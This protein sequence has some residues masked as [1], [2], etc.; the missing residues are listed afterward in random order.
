MAGGNRPRLLTLGVAA[1]G[2]LVGHW[3]T[4][5]ISVPDGGARAATLRVTGHAYL[6]IA[7]E[8]ASALLALSIVG[9]FLGALVDRG[10]APRTPRSLTARLILL[11]VGAFAG[12]E[13]A[14]RFLSGSPL[15]ELARGGILPVGIVA[16]AAIAALGAALLR[17]LLRL[18]E[19]VADAAPGRTPTLADLGHGV[20]AMLDPSPRYLAEPALAAAPARGP[21]LPDCR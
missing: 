11:Q 7:G 13:V 10:G 15:A 18:A 2:V 12:M 21:P 16:N 14:E 1:T 9:V 20:V 19:R 6:G 5:L 8:L 3:L 4:Y 17:R